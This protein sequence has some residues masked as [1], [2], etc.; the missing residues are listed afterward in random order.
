MKPCHRV[1][2]HLSEIALNQPDV[3]VI[4]F[5]HEGIFSQAATDI[6]ALKAFIKMKGNLQYPIFVD[7]NRIAI[8]GVL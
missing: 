1:F 3:K 2:D 5:N 8:N 6:E 7:I 4:T